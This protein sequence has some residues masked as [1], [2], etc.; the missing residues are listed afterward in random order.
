VTLYLPVILGTIRHDRK[1]EW[2]ARFVVDRLGKRPGVSS[3]LVDPRELPF[4]NLDVREW[5]MDPQPPAVA[6]FVQDMARADGF[7]I[8]APEYNHGSSGAAPVPA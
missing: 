2:V 7:V 5:E 6:A 1:S 3:R 8:V 4:G